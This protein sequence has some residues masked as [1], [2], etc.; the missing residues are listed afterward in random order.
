MLSPVCIGDV[1]ATNALLASGL[2]VECDVPHMLSHV[3]S[4]VVSNTGMCSS[5]YVSVD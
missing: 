5:V 4:K 2:T 1:K 3:T